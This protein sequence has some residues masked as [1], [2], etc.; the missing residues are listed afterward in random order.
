M[1]DSEGIVPGEGDGQENVPKAHDPQSPQAKP[2]EGLV[3]STS[4]TGDQREGALPQIVIQQPPPPPRDWVQIIVAALPGVAALIALIFTYA[5]LKGQLQSNTDQLQATRSQLTIES[6][7]QI[8]DRFNAAIANLGS[9]AIDVRIG[10]IYALQRIMIDSHRDQPAILEVLTAF[11]RDHSPAP[12]RPVT[13]G[14]PVPVPTPALHISIPAYLRAGVTLIGIPADV[15]AALDVIGDRN[16]A[17][18]S[19]AP[20]DLAN[21]NLDDANMGGLNFNGAIFFGSDLIGANLT[22][23][24]LVGADF[25]EADLFAASLVQAS[26]GGAW[27]N[28]TNLVAAKL[29]DASLPTADFGMK[30]YGSLQLSGADLSSANFSGADIKGANF[31]GAKLSGVIGLR[32]KA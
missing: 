4:Q 14:K 12:G 11:V 9:K 19:A 7:G 31:R 23:A 13:L 10:G 30:E 18:D 15:Q 29:Q 8:T 27:F 32:S 21:T 24:K 26:L 20:I 1:T 17:F 3:E 28:A 5:S 16:A 22:Q 25:Q 2:P 6:Q